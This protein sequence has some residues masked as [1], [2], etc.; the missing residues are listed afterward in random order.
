MLVQV[1]LRPAERDEPARLWRAMDGQAGL[2]DCLTQSGE[3]GN[4][5]MLGRSAVY[6]RRTIA[7]RAGSVVPLR[8]TP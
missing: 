5:I 4:L 7:G 8:G 6:P 3:A 1:I 2:P